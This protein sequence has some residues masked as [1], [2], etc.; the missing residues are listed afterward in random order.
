MTTL[1]IITEQ[2]PHHFGFN[3]FDYDKFIDGDNKYSELEIKDGELYCYSI[4]ISSRYD[5]LD[6]FLQMINFCKMAFKLRFCQFIHS[7]DYDSKSCTCSVTFQIGNKLIDSEDSELLYSNE[8]H[9]R[10]ASTALQ[11][12]NKTLGQHFVLGLCSGLFHDENSEMYIDA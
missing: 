9:Y 6:E 1:A 8:S 10:I 5:K 2:S 4:K 7:L 11:I 12:A 3:A